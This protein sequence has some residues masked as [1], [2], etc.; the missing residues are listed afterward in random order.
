MGDAV[1]HVDGREGTVL[2]VDATGVAKVDFG[3]HVGNVPLAKLGFSKTHSDGGFNPSTVDID[4][5][6][7]DVKPIKKWSANLRA[8]PV[9][10]RT[11]SEA[12]YRVKTLPMV[13][14]TECVHVHEHG[15]APSTCD[16]VEGSVDGQH[17]CSL[18][19]LV[20]S[21][22]DQ[23]V[24]HVRDWKAWDE[25]REASGGTA[26]A[27]A[28]GEET[29]GAHTPGDHVLPADVKTKAEIDYVTKGEAAWKAHGLANLAAHDA[30]KAAEGDHETASHAEGGAE[31][32]ASTSTHSASQ[33]DE[34]E[35]AS[36]GMPKAAATKS[37]S[38]TEK[39]ERD[40]LSSRFDWEA[41]AVNAHEPTNG[42]Q[43]KP[44]IPG[45]NPDRLGRFA[46]GYTNAR[47][48]ARDRNLSAEDARAAYAA[49]KS[50]QAKDPRTGE[51]A[52]AN[53]PQAERR[54][55]AMGYKAHALE[56]EGKGHPA[57]W[58]AHDWS[59]GNPGEARRVESPFA[60]DSEEHANFARGY[61][62]ATGEARG[63]SMDKEQAAAR[64][65]NHQ[66]QSQHDISAT[67]KAFHLGAAKGF[68]H[69]AAEAPASE[70]AAAPEGINDEHFTQGRQEAMRQIQS[71]NLL[72]EDSAEKAELHEEKSVNTSGADSARHAGMSSAFKEHAEREPSPQDKIRHEA[73][74]SANGPGIAPEHAADYQEGVDKATRHIEEFDLDQATTSKKS[75]REMQ[76]AGRETD[77]AKRAH[78][79]GTAAAYRAHAVHGD[80]DNVPRP[81]VIEPTVAREPLK[82]T[83]SPDHETKSIADFK[84]SD[85]QTP[86]PQGVEEP[87]TIAEL[88]AEA[89]RVAPPSVAKVPTVPPG[90]KNPVGTR[91]THKTSNQYII[92]MSNGSL[93]KFHEWGE[94]VRGA[95]G[96]VQDVPPHKGGAFEEALDK[97][98][99]FTK[100]EV[101]TDDDLKPPARPV[102]PPEPAKIEQQVHEIHEP[103]VASPSVAAV[104]TPKTAGEDHAPTKLAA[105]DLKPGD[106]VRFYDENANDHKG[107]NREEVLKSVGPHL[108]SYAQKGDLQFHFAGHEKPWGQMVSGTMP[109][110]RIGEGFPTDEAHG[111]ESHAP[112]VAAS[113]AEA[114]AAAGER[115]IENPY[116]EGSEHFG[117]FN[118]LSSQTFRN[119]EGMNPV[120]SDAKAM[121]HEAKAAN[122]V[123]EAQR[124]QHLGTA[125]GLLRRSK[126]ERDWST[127]AYRGPVSGH[128][129]EGNPHPQ[130]T[131]EHDAFRQ[132][133]IVARR[134]SRHDELSA[135]DAQNQVDHQ[136]GILNSMESRKPADVAKVQGKIQGYQ[137]H[138][139]QL[140]NPAPSEFSSAHATAFM[141]VK[142]DKPTADLSAPYAKPEHTDLENSVLTSSLNHLSKGNVTPTALRAEAR[143]DAEQSVTTA[144]RGYDGEALRATA[145]GKLKA[146]D[147]YENGGGKPI[148][149][150]GGTNRPPTEHTMMSHLQPGDRI[151]HN[152]EPQFV[153]SNTKE[154][155]KMR[156][157]ETVSEKTGEITNHAHSGNTWYERLPATIKE[158]TL[159]GEQPPRLE[160]SHL[161]LPQQA[162]AP[163]GHLHGSSD[164]ELSA[165]HAQGA[166]DA[167]D[168]LKEL[169]PS[170]DEAATHAASL[171]DEIQE[172]PRTQAEEQDHAYKTGMAE[173]YE[174]HAAVPPSISATSAGE[175]RPSAPKDDEP[176]PS[177]VQPGHEDAYRQ[178]I[179]DG[180][181]HGTEMH[182]NQGKTAAQVKALASNKYF[183]DAKKS[184][185]EGDFSSH[186]KNYGFAR[187][188][189]RA[190]SEKRAMDKAPT[191][192]AVA[193]G[194]EEGPATDLGTNPTNNAEAT[195]APSVVEQATETPTVS[196][197]STN[198]S[199]MESAIAR[200]TD[201]G[202]K[203]DEIQGNAARAG[204]G[205]S[206]SKNEAI[207]RAM[208]GEAQQALSKGDYNHAAWLDAHAKGYQQALGT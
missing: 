98:G 157:M 164:S 26:A 66:E 102:A 137:S 54:G 88:Q 200:A 163:V 109:M 14:C 206:R 35:R 127:A 41:R 133:F 125:A 75:E 119:T 34:A 195:V 152:G 56:L 89:G 92:K 47:H 7:V 131:K 159:H 107:A 64:A 178:G 46:K 86:L 84:P 117:T 176:V 67:E 121:E 138:I 73:I 126:E 184:F 151:W 91:W 62:S 181:A 193:S 68:E 171:R 69:H 161:K 48:D 95:D 97:S 76:A 2:T 150:E 79:L 32:V 207:V 179:Q 154:P 146:A 153:H 194:V 149:K 167:R 169:N 40:A 203:Y 198:N 99:A 142:P 17:V 123:D 78:Y 33:N 25:D 129:I 191:S 202:L 100:E 38:D 174:S 6:A 114:P 70:H 166:A 3:D 60:P 162:V 1:T 21:H 141:D 90:G 20:E 37:M 116:E 15:E 118:H 72:P 186:A 145:N 43:N 44:Y 197:S 103:K 139:E 132:N 115:K 82:I 110:S 5:T 208:N 27:H 11:K 204:A 74:R 165:A 59:M 185:D 101:D 168:E 128:S 104:E 130:G 155:G 172:R 45:A 189:G 13:A 83:V 120:T 148:L 190:A 52:L 136:T 85:L 81:R 87:K 180:Y 199:A 158:P 144:S 65:I 122:A 28:G 143:Q 49:H 188:L 12:G 196:S 9:A 160:D 18:F 57:Q 58:A 51:K 201:E 55:V 177:A 147:Q 94:P 105:K 53:P 93:R 156:Q 22:I 140:K 113:E 10:L 63:G 39:S 24:M 30:E 80:T 112:E 182:T 61:R 71:G 23:S 135:E 4:P 183:K 170:R 19:A 42:S 124:V 50:L 175:E 205:N 16:L 106:K 31:D 8:Q 192:N 134:H 111:E 108:G 36:R 187:G 77:E 29:V 96:K 173:T